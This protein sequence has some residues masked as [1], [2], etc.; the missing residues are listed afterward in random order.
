MTC[1][2]L[3]LYA[4]RGPSLRTLTLFFLIA[5][6]SGCGSLPK[7][8]RNLGKSDVD[9][10]MDTHARQ[11][12]QQLITLTRKL[13]VRNPNQLARSP[14]STIDSRIEQ[15]FGSEET[16]E[17]PSLRFDELGGKT[18]IDAILLSFDEQYRGDRVFAAMAG[19]AEMLRRSYNHQ[20]EFFILDSLNEQA[21]Y[22]SARNIE[23]FVW[24]LYHRKDHTGELM[25]YTNDI[26]QN[27]DDMSFDRILTKIIM[28]QDMMAL[29]VADKTDRSITKI[30]QGVAQFSFI[31]VL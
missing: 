18:G 22:N 1:Y 17:L 16:I 7:P 6:L 28:L 13:Y 20:Q 21:L 10:V 9:F 19:L 5:C 15:L 23:V 2:L 25:L 29:I 24:R 26:S 12:K 27:G 3:Y 11:L 14:H 31:P 30:V 4:H 8:I